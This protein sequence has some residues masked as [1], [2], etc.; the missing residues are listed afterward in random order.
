MQYVYLLVNPHI[1]KLVKFGFSR[2]SPALRA[3]ELSAPTGVPGNWEVRHFWEVD[4]GYAVEQE[5]FGRLAKKRLGRQEFLEMEPAEAITQISEIIADAGTNQIWRVK[6][7]LAQV[8]CEENKRAKIENEL[9]ILEERRRQAYLF[10]IHETLST[11]HVKVEHIVAPLKEQ[12]EQKRSTSNMWITLF[13]FALGYAVF[14]KNKLAGAVFG[15]VTFGVLGWL[16]G[17]IPKITDNFFLRN[18]LDQLEVSRKR[19]LLQVVE[20]EGLT[21]EEYSA[22]QKTV[23]PL[24]PGQIDDLM[25]HLTNTSWISLEE[26]ERAL[27][28]E[29]IDI[30]KD[31]DLQKFLQLARP[32]IRKGK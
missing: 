4:D 30:A 20:N 31:Q 6:R 7:D 9:R 5:V 17:V 19:T 1:P 12:V 23:R 28:E 15:A 8:L 11:I 24:L 25:Q 29:E 32:P 22:L 3:E 18:L 26:M 10:S 16:L 14:S 21:M 2:R 13:L 27:V